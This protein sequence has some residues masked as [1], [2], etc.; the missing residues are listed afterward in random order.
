MYRILKIIIASL[1][2]MTLSTYTVYLI[3]RIE[4]SD[5][6]LKDHKELLVRTPSKTV[7]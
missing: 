3:Y 1:E 2:S 6:L 7:A 4:Y 5:N